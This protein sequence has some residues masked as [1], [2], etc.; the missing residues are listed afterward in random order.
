MKI[1]LHHN[2][3][4]FFNPLFCDRPPKKRITVLVISILFGFATGGI[5]HAIYFTCKGIK[6]ANTDKSKLKTNLFQ[7]KVNPTAVKD[8][9]NYWERK[10]QRE[11]TD[12]W[13]KEELGIMIDVLANSEIKCPYEQIYGVFN[14]GVQSNLVFTE[15]GAWC[16]ER[17][18]IQNLGEDEKSKILVL[19][20]PT[21]EVCSERVNR[22]YEEYF[23]R[24]VTFQ[25]E[26]KGISLKA[27]TYND[28]QQLI[29]KKQVPKNLQTV[30]QNT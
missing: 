29:Q 19:F 25:P 17:K 20:I 27:I 24:L 16:L 1:K 14:N 18:R 7:Q 21:D 5:P 12:K 3:H 8:N 2:V 13:C 4:Q 30:L 28:Y 26:L 23:A 10:I 22:P 9:K 15:D 11:G 6:L